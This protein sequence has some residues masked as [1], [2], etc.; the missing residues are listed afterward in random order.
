MGASTHSGWPL[1]GF[2]CS[3]L[4]IWTKFS[5]CDSRASMKPSSVFFRSS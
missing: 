1:T 2:P 3:L 4:S 5:D